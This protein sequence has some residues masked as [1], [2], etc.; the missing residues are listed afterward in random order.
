MLDTVTP[1][2]RPRLT[3]DHNEL[4]VEEAGQAATLPSLA[5]T[6]ATVAHWL[7]QGV[8]A[9]LQQVAALGS[10]EAVLTLAGL[11]LVLHVRRWARPWWSASCST[12]P[13]A[14]GA[15]GGSSSGATGAAWV[16]ACQLDRGLEAAPADC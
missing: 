2:L 8:P 6:R 15:G 1:L 9:D 7:Q 11:T 3:G 12:R 14:A 4:I 16:A 10:H 5:Q 13:R